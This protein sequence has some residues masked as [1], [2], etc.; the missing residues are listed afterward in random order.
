MIVKTVISWSKPALWTRRLNV[1]AEP[2]LALRNAIDP[3]MVTAV[4]IVA[5]QI[6]AYIAMSATLEL[7][8]FFDDA[9]VDGHRHSRPP[10]ACF[11]VPIRG[12]SDYGAR[13]D[14]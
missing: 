9:F 6:V 4:T 12:M 13:P 3:T 10:L 11:A 7:R 14:H 5:K 8:D 1:F 2:G